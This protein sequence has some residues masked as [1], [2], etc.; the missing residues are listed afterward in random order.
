MKTHKPLSTKKPPFPNEDVEVLD[1][2]LEDLRPKIAP[3][4]IELH[5]LVLNHLSNP[6]FAVKWGSAF[7][8]SKDKGWVIQ[9]SSYNVSA[10]IVFLNGQHLSNPPQMGDKTRYVK[11]SSLAEVQDNQIVKW[12][13]ESC[14]TEG[15]A[16]G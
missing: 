12:V 8:G 16:W 6:R 7:Y 10:N 13:K 3:V 14:Q 15:W 5:S 11:L 1:E 2:W 9:L 4:V